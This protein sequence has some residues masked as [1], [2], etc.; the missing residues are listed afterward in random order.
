MAGISA[1]AQLEA[2]HIFYQSACLP[3]S[4]ACNLTVCALSAAALDIAG[5]IMTWYVC[6]LQVW[7]PGLLEVCMVIPD[8]QPI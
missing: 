4:V 7:I 8:D 1:V 5:T 3:L 6:C 2:E